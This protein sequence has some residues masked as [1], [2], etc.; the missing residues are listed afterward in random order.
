MVVRSAGVRRLVSGVLEAAFFGLATALLGCATAPDTRKA[1]SSL[2]RPV[3]RA[4][5]VRVGPLIDL[6][7]VRSSRDRVKVV[8]DSGNQVRV[9]IASTE[10]RQVLELVVR[11]EGVVERRVVLAQ[12]APGTIDAA[13]DG[14][15][16]L[17]ALVDDEH[18]VLEDGKWRVSERSPWREAGLTPLRGAFFV[19]GAPNLTW[20]FHVRGADVGA[21]GRLEIYGIGGAAGALIWP[22]FTR[23]E[24]AVIVVET[25]TGYGPWVVLEP[26]AKG[27][28]R[29]EALAADASGAVNVL[30][31]ISTGGIA[32]ESWGRYARIRAEVLSDEECTFP[33]VTQT[34][35]GSRRCRAFTGSVD[36]VYYRHALAVDPDTGIALVG[37]R[38]LRRGD[39]LIGGPFELPLDVR[40]SSPDFRAAAAGRGA[41][42]A[43]VSATAPGEKGSAFAWY[44]L[45]SEREWF[46]PI[47]LGPTGAASFFGTEWDAYGI[48]GLHEGRAFVV[49]PTEHGI[50]GRWVERSD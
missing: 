10:L 9:L 25:P 4:P 38:Y 6:L 18:L 42:H 37:L 44:L 3:A 11:P 41:F 46:A 26:N 47:L 31:T 22:W 50:V 13:F 17:H 33:G 34:E 15:G 24:R 45:F 36:G 2:D 29:V 20:A 35:V 1:Q 30:Y 16:K 49:W 48:A 23:G 39:E 43:V 5:N 8:A 40:P 19:P 27:D 32:G 12:A 28:T 21:R 7:V 14:S